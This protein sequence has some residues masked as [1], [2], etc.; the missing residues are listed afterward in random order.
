MMFILTCFSTPFMRNL[1]IEK[2]IGS[3]DEHEIGNCFFQFFVD[4]DI[5][6]TNEEILGLLASS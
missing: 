5:V 4:S 2:T 1:N 6:L 3:L